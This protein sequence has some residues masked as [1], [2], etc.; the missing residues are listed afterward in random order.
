MRREF[1]TKYLI[2]LIK[3]VQVSKRNMPKHFFH[4]KTPCPTVAR[5]NFK[6]SY[7]GLM[8]QSFYR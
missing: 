5:I 8:A 6:Y 3:I 1:E 7:Q 2:A 4:R